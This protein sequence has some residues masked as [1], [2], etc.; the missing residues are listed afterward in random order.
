MP[1]LTKLWLPCFFLALSTGATRF[2]I[3][4]CL[5]D[6]WPALPV[7]VQQTPCRRIQRSDDSFYIWYFCPCSRQQEAT[8]VTTDILMS[9]SGGGMDVALNRFLLQPG[10]PY[11]HL[12]S[13]R[14]KIG[15]R[16]VTLP[17]RTICGS[18]PPSANCAAVPLHWTH[19]TS[20][21][22]S[23]RSCPR[24]R[25]TFRPLCLGKH[26]RARRLRHQA[27]YRPCRKRLRK[28]TP[29]WKRQV[30]TRLGTTLAGWPTWLAPCAH[31]LASFRC[32]WLLQ[33][34]APLIRF[35]A[36]RSTNAR[37]KTAPHGLHST[38]ALHW[39]QPA[40][41]RT[42]LW[43]RP[44]WVA[45]TPGLQL[46]PSWIGCPPCRPYPCLACS[47][48]MDPLHDDVLEEALADATALA[49]PDDTAALAGSDNE[50]VEE[51]TAATAKPEARDAEEDA[52][53]EASH[54]STWSAAM[55][56]ADRS[57]SPSRRG[58]GAGPFGPP[59]A[60]SIHHPLARQ[61]IPS[62]P[63]AEPPAMPVDL[64]SS[65]HRHRTTPLGSSS[66]AR[67]PPAIPSMPGEPDDPHW[68]RVMAVNVLNTLQHTGPAFVHAPALA[69]VKSWNSLRII[70]EEATEMDEV[71]C[72]RVDPQDLSSAL[73]VAGPTEAGADADGNHED[74]EA[75]PY[76]EGEEEEDNSPDEDPSSDPDEPG[77][78]GADGPAPPLTGTEASDLTRPSSG[79]PL[80]SIHPITATAASEHPSSTRPGDWVYEAEGVSFNL[81]AAHRCL[82][83]TRRTVAALRAGNRHR[84]GPA[85][86]RDASRSRSR[87]RSPRQDSDMADRRGVAQ[88]VLCLT[89]AL[90]FQLHWASP[91]G[92]TSNPPP[93]KHGRSQ[94]EQF[95]WNP[96]C[97]LPERKNWLPSVASASWAGGATDSPITYMHSLTLASRLHRYSRFTRRASAKPMVSQAWS[98]CPKV[99]HALQHLVNRLYQ[100]ICF[101]L[102]TL[103]AASLALW[104]YAVPASPS[105]CNTAGLPPISASPSLPTCSRP[106]PNS[107]GSLVCRMQPLIILIC[108][109]PACAGSRA[110]A[111]V[112]AHATEAAGGTMLSSSDLPASMPKL[113]GFPTTTR[114]PPTASMRRCAKR[115]FRRACH[116]AVLFGRTKYKGRDLLASE[117]P[118][119]Q[120]RPCPASRDSHKPGQSRP[121][122]GIQVMTWNA[123]GL[124]G[125]VYDELLTHLSASTI[126]IAV[127][128]ESRWTECME[129][130]SGPWTCVHSGCKTRRHAGLLVLMHS[131]LVAPSQVRFEHL[132]KGRLLHVRVPLQ[133]ADRRHL[134][135]IAIYQKTHDPSD[136]SA[137]QQRQQV[138][139][140]LHQCLSRLP[141]RDSIVLLGDFNTPLR[142]FPPYVGSFVGSPLS[143][144]PDDIPDLEVLMQ[145]HKLT[146]LNSWYKPQGGVHT[147]SFGKAK[148]QIDYI[149]VRQTEASTQARRVFAHHHFKVGAA[150]QGGAFHIP[151]QT[152]L[153]LSRPYWVHSGQRPRESIDQEAPSAGH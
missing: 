85:S 18:L 50:G 111:R 134:H 61:Y 44:L 83:E 115:A 130:T 60:I 98:F 82:E 146:A 89:S 12:V 112:A 113:G 49:A 135:I 58:A 97:V 72:Q 92:D 15:V 3:G 117:I 37:A 40:L 22:L 104:S 16:N 27:R 1:W 23:R 41:P 10:L 75:E 127:I 101:C 151:L 74:A 122:T 142:A 90:P 34:V 150:R 136:K 126:D 95:D 7:P 33:Q 26:L 55:H 88:N 91:S 128:Q 141:A 28:R 106:G 121:S 30:I 51:T 31:W 87:P 144:P 81:H 148:T 56:A 46:T 145:S 124:G 107:R 79:D 43:F 118:S 140:S 70:L 64:V 67:G 116:R 149:M 73:H 57:P 62:L 38:R 4:A 20:R 65:R 54:Y 2:T 13:T 143:H 39:G 71:C 105:R 6:Q 76:D 19:L 153:S 42:S 125:G 129:Y 110:E 48:T 119:D 139:N 109:H 96:S 94:S 84:R 133:S 35:I 17:L 25:T 9:S 99:V 68:Q 8:A 5:R 47:A 108:L 78:D 80:H 32:V 24:P 102:E 69:T 11:I 132:L 123:G 14:F 29:P 147:F 45:P 103:K 152:T 36:S 93:L 52:T 59:P 138:W 21:A 86:S 100:C 77:P 114:P 53:S 131:R 63:S 66:S 120:R 137:P